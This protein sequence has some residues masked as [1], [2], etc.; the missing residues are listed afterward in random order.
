MQKQKK[1]QKSIQTS[2]LQASEAGAMIER[3]LE[4]VE[5]FGSQAAD[6]T[7]ELEVEERE[8]EKIRDSLKEKTQGFSDQ[9]AV[10]R[11]SL[12]P[13]NERINE[14]RS[15]IA[16]AQ[17]ELDIMHE[18][19]NT[20]RLALTDAQAK[21][22]TIEQA[23]LTKEAELDQC[24]QE[25]AGLEEQ[26]AKLHAQLDSMAQKEPQLKTQLSSAREKADEARS[27]MASAQSQ[28]QVLTA[29]MRLMESGRIEGFHGRLGNL[30][31]IDAKYDVAVSTAC[32]SLENMVVDSVE[33][34]Q[35]CIEYLRKTNLGRANFICLDRLP[36]RDLSRIRT[37]ENA[38]RLF[39]LITPKAPKFAPA[40]Y[41]VL[42]NTLVAADLQQANRVAYGAQ[43][44]RV[45]TLDG[46]LIDKSGAMTG[47]GT[48]V[49]K[50][51][52][53]SKLPTQISKEAIQRLERE[54]NALEQSYEEFL[55][56]QREL[57]AAVR[58][59]D[60]RIPDLDIAMSKIELEI[61]SSAQHMADARRRIKELTKERRSS[62]TD[63]GRVSALEKKIRSLEGEVEQLQDETA[64][65]EH[66][67]QELQDKIMQ[68]G[69]INLRSQKSKVDGI[70][71]QLE[72]LNEQVTAAELSRTKSG[73]A[74]KKAETTIAAGETEFAANED[75]LEAIR[76][77]MKEHQ[78]D[79]R[80]SQG[81]AQEAQS[82]LETKKDELA[83]FKEDLD[84]RL[85]A[86][87]KTRAAEIEMK[88]K[89]DE[90]QKVLVEN[91]K[92][93][94]HWQAELSKLRFQ[95]IK[96]LSGESRDSGDDD[97]DDGN[98]NSNNNGSGR[99]RNKKNRNKRSQGGE[100]NEGDD[101]VDDDDGDDSDDNNGD[102]DNDDD[103]NHE[104]GEDGGGRAHRQGLP[105]YTEDELADMDRADLQSQIAVLEGKI[106]DI[107]IDLSV[108]AEY[109]RRVE[110]YTARN[111]D[112]QV[113][114]GNRDA[115]RR[116]LDDLRKRRLDE[117]MEGFNIISLRLKE[118]YQMITMGG[119]A[120]L[121]LVDSLDPFSEGI[122]FSVM[123]PKKSWKNISNLSGGEKTLSSLA[124]VFALHHYKPTPLYVMDEIDA[125]LDF[126]NVSIVAGYIKERTKNAQFIVISLRN[127]MFE[128]A[129]R[130]VGVY[131]V[132]HM[133]CFSSLLPCLVERGLTK[134]GQIDKERND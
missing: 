13:W 4:D 55:A 29:L 106:K 64:G 40:F 12:E 134:A 14:K 88:N 49:S 129:A 113:A 131:K 63:K 83:A 115:V 69:G 50:G 71:E 68:V 98:D 80:E 118:M 102:D 9:I 123:P 65:A 70:R 97:G 3:R 110:E 22:G 59:I 127:N 67:I 105:V 30:G 100:S 15:A 32:P 92:R 76:N 36:K 103:G 7:R 90:H 48:T 1:L 52:M 95:N 124:L 60:Q 114:V 125:A 10:K 120:E 11:K 89:L 5:R 21:V 17:S 96:D 104:E 107:N 24:R 41:S 108:L 57:Q 93:S 34:G 26:V 19:G 31:T 20:A 47:G 117:F 101:D 79:A 56:Q 39:D 35:Q 43:R 37:P 44:W 84:E 73:K 86:L 122:L 54:R 61:R 51:R 46:Q 121:E 38:A 126:R 53:S 58:D 6:L 78:Q 94:R 112:L 77:G 111:N 66:E 132:N 91:Q 87:N 82:F 42:S 130:L 8:L 116:R 33:V 74:R 72:T 2:K 128:L 99:E 18:R 81:R 25:R 27:S 109:R 133:V 16:V 62:A 119:N 28:G 45:V 75:E 85:A 23:R